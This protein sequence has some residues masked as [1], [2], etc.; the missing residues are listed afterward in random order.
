M[1]YQKCENSTANEIYDANCMKYN[2]IRALLLCLLK[3]SKKVYAQKQWE[4][5]SIVG[6]GFTLN[7]EKYALIENWIKVTINNY[8]QRDIDLNINNI[9]IM[10][11]RSF[12]LVL[13]YEIWV[14]LFKTK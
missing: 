8:K 13:Y 11:L 4:S 1:S 7:N 6:Y 3:A 10:I 2:R 5:N 12:Q 14:M 9:Y